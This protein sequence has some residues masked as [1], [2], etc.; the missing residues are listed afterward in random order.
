MAGVGVTYS[1]VTLAA[2]LELYEQLLELAKCTV[3]DTPRGTSPM[4]RS[5][6]RESGIEDSLHAAAQHPGGLRRLVMQT[7]ALRGMPV[8]VPL[9][10]PCVSVAMDCP[11]ALPSSCCPNLVMGSA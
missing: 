4:S 6:A 1:P 11:G 9:T 5:R 8:Y 10:V 7:F 2:A 3:G